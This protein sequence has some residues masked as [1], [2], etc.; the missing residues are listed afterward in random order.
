MERKLLFTAVV[1]AWLALP[2][3]ALNFSRAWDRLP[4]RIAVHF[5][6]DWQPNG[7]TSREGAS[8]LALGTTGFSAPRVHDRCFCGEPFAYIGFLQVGVSG[9][10]LYRA[11]SGLLR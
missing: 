7:W 10:V 2:L 11:R 8:T 1:L 5:D 6:A 9:G 4:Q 3:T